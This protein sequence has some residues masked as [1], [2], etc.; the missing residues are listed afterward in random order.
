MES[1]FFQEP[2]DESR[3]SRSVETGRFQDRLG[4]RS[5]GRRLRHRRDRLTS[6]AA[7]PRSRDGG[8]RASAGLQVATVDCGNWRC[9]ESAKAHRSRQWLLANL[10]ANFRTVSMRRDAF[11]E[12]I[13]TVDLS[14]DLVSFFGGLCR[15]RKGKKKQKTKTK[16]KPDADSSFGY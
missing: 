6:A 9:G 8:A 2:I 10:S 1:F 13:A 16:S 14:L 5:A 7:P 12:L 3:M 15:K 4:I 11:L